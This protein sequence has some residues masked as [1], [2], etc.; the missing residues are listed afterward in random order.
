MPRMKFPCSL[1]LALFVSTSLAVAET[2]EADIV[3]FGGTSGGIAAAVQ[4]Q[5]MG[6]SVAIAEWT[7]HLGG[8]T[9]GGL[10]ATG[11]GNKGAIGGIAREFYEQIHTHYADEKNWKWQK[12]VPGVEQSKGKDPVVAKTGRE[13][14]GTFEPQVAMQK[15]DC[16]ALKTRL[17]ADGQILEWTGPKREMPAPRPKLGG[18]VLNDEDAE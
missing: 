1:S 6:R 8:L 17:L 15:I 5:R 10:G 9:T 16:A 7:N 3:I 12:P 14:K 18:L 13:T 2:I 11:I 4:A